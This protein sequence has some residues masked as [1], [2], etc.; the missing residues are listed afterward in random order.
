MSAFSNT[1]RFAQ[2]RRGFTEECVYRDALGR[3]E[4][5]RCFVVDGPLD[6]PAFLSAGSTRSTAH[7]PRA[8]VTERASAWD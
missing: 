2:V 6:A 4:P 5:L 7:G 8:N 3:T 1:T